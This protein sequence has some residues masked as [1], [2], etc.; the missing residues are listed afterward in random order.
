[1]MTASI[2][3]STT[4]MMSGDFQYGKKERRSPGGG[5]R[6]RLQEGP[7]DR[8]E[9]SPWNPQGGCRLDEAGIRVHGM[10]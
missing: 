2:V 1:M 9:L 7:R 10:A 5:S 6:W 4:T 8:K 3:G